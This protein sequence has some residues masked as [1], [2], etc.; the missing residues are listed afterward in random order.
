M[1]ASLKKAGI[2]FVLIATAGWVSCGGGGS[3]KPQ[4]RQSFLA[5]RVFLT[6]SSTSNG[7]GVVEII[8]A[9][10]DVFGN[11]LL[12]VAPGSNVLATT[13]PGKVSVTSSKT[14]A[15]VAV[16]DNTLEAVRGFVSLPAETESMAVTP[17]GKWAFAAVH[18]TNSIELID[19]SGVKLCTTLTT[20]CTGPITVSAPTKIVMNGD[21][22]KLLAFSDDPAHA[23]SVYVIDIP[24]VT[25]ATG[26]ST[27]TEVAGFGDH[28]VNA[29]FASDNSTAYV[30]LCGDECGGATGPGVRTLNA[31]ATSPAPISG[32]V[33]VSGGA[34]VG[35]LDGS[36]LFVAGTPV[37]TQGTLNGG[38]VTQINTTTL[39]VS[40]PVPITAG[41][42]DNMGVQAGKV[43][44]GS[45]T[46]ST[47]PNPGCLSIYDESSG[48]V[49]PKVVTPSFQGDVTSILPISGRS[50]VYVIVD[51]E[52]QMFDATTSTLQSQQLDIVGHAE[53]VVQVDP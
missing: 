47:P 20:D 10:K 30:M 6:N 1:G 25:K 2:F 38:N 41:L 36:N 46:C 32:F 7:A 39:A 4:R 52:L 37:G 23:D 43:F 19:L 42:H 44:I 3:S 24:T 18:N 12:T 33:A 9:I 14:T 27:A 40:N 31:K 51:G 28:A 17:D 15:Q 13:I 35:A 8:D 34:T 50:V 16:I 26:P 48:F 45:R 21:G 22:T 53:Q 29:V 5:K 11:N 49:N